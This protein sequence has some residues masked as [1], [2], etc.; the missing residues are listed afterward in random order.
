MTPT[1]ST[2]YGLMFFDIPTSQKLVYYRIKNLVNKYCVPV[3]LSVYIFDWGLKEKIEQEINDSKANV[4]GLCSIVKF[5][6]MSTDQ[7]ELLATNQ[8][9]MI[10]S[11]ITARIEKTR[12]ILARDCV[13]R[14]IY[15]QLD[16]RLQDYENL[17][18]FY[19]FF[20]NIEP[21]MNLLRNTINEAYKTV[22][23]EDAVA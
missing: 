17:A 18:T 15:K 1:L 12:T 16:K 20:K 8:L 6:S 21:T 19:G 10:F 23:V 11:K 5:D 3:N 13:K 22:A 2:A 7:L 14:S 9:R 4:V